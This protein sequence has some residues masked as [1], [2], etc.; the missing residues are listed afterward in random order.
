MSDNKN[1]A[2]IGEQPHYLPDNDVE[3]SRSGE[4]FILKWHIPVKV[5]VWSGKPIS[6]IAERYAE[7]ESYEPGCYEK[8]S[9]YGHRSGKRRIR[10]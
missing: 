8:N 6:F 3:P 1:G 4:P 5:S 10:F 2:A 7:T 9:D